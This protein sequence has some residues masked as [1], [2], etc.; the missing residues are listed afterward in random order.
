M[1]EKDGD[2]GKSTK[3]VVNKKQK[4]DIQTEGIRLKPKKEFVDGIKNIPSNLKKVKDYLIP[5]PEKSANPN[6]RSG[7]Y[8]PT[9]R[10]LKL[11]TLKSVTTD[12]AKGV[13][14]KIW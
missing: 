14:E 5:P 4:P 12:A 3:S 10:G 8:T 9:N 2:E 6:V 1:P 7:K 11:P 13:Q